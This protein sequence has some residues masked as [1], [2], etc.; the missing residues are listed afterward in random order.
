V[1]GSA[2]SAASEGVAIAM[3]PGVGSLGL[4]MPCAVTARTR[5]TYLISESRP[6]T[7]AL[8]AVDVPSANVVHEKPE[9]VE[10]S[11]M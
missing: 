5:N 3:M 1:E 10:N 11:R 4:P 2:S 7:V 9:F 6:V 8:V